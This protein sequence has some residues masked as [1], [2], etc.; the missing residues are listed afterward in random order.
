MSLCTFTRFITGVLFCIFA[1]HAVAQKATIETLKNKIQ[2][3]EQQSNYKKDTAWLNA[4]NM[5]AFIYAETNPD[6]SLQLLKNHDSYCREAD[7]A[8]GEAG[9]F[10]NAGVA[11]YNKGDYAT[12]IEKL[13][14]AV[15]LC[16]KHKLSAFLPK[17][18]NN[19]GLTAMAQGN[20]SRALQFYYETLS[21]ADAVKDKATA[22]S[23]Y[24]NI[25][26]VYYYQ[27][28][29]D[30]A[31]LNYKKFLEVSTQL[32]DTDGIV[33]ANNNIGEVYLDK[34]E[35]VKAKDY[36]TSAL[37]TASLAGRK[38]SLISANKNL[39]LL[40]FKTGSFELAA[41]YFKQAAELAFETGYKPSACIALTGLAKTLHKQ[42]KETEALTYAQ[43]ALSMAH[44]M[45]QPQLMRDANE[46]LATIYE[47]KGDGIQ[48]LKHYKMFKQYADSLRN[49]EAE[50][51]GE[52]LKA[53]FDFS[54]KELEFARKNLQQRWLIF[55]V[56]AALA[57]AL[58]VI[59]LVYRSRQKEKK[60]NNAL[61]EQNE[62]IEKQKQKAETTL[63]KLQAAQ[64]QLIQSEKM[65]SLGELTAGIA[66]EI[67]NPLN[68]VNNFSE[69]SRELI[70]ELKGERQKAE[71][72][73]NSE[74]E[75]ELL[76]DISA[77][78]EKINHHGKRA[79][80][81]VKGM[82]QHS[83]ISSGVKEPTDINA[84]ADE[85]L[86][87]AYHGLRAKDK[88]FNATMKTDFDESIGNIN[89]IPQDMGRVILNL[90]TNAFYVVGERQKVEG[91][92]HK[93]E[94]TLHPTPSTLNPAYE[95]TVSVSTKKVS[96]KVEIKVA[97]NGNG[98]PQKILDKIF[99]PFFTTK[100]TGQGTGLGLS[101]SYDIV[102]AHGG[103]LKV[104]T[105][106]GVG[107]SFTIHLPL[108][109][110]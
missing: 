75:N 100:P 52:R 87:L 77:N 109:L 51:T 41:R 56:F 79:A 7:F 101:L 65:A 68:F 39:G 40:Y 63:E 9:A 8:V 88:T 96:D 64:K 105:K 94:N 97:D 60:A 66:H 47:S 38:R 85:Y 76:T 72:E 59:Y 13:N 26:I 49:S 23:T 90:I 22:A 89:I 31:E 25:A 50:R 99:Q 82:L 98:I 28:K 44:E 2:Q 84:L 43:Q 4:V 91:I 11:Y 74:L 35:F 102:K 3:L 37:T 57:T 29:L 86:R 53:E 55:S 58:L 54:K 15:E 62:L 61:H 42:G 27:N 73:R 110:I 20:Y 93:E 17:V 46:I 67:Q 48:A 1:H 83:R 33:I 69:V 103:E 36:F 81:I 104:E 92:R 5:L 21:A 32:H 12:S 71:G 78:L 14:L 108:I 107:S 10:C 106:E 70:D 24:N 18:L 45:G 95:P 6:S 19:L 34:N 30:E 16:K 80:D